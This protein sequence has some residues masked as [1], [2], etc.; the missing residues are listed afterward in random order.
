M[1]RKRA[2]AEQAEQA[3]QEYGERKANDM[4][5]PVEVV[6]APAGVEQAIDRSDAIL[7]TTPEVAAMLRVSQR[8]IAA[9]IE[10]GPAHGGIGS[11]RLDGARRISR[12]QLIDFVR[13]LTERC[14]ATAA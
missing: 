5:R 6:V 13:K 7:L 12:D 3:E 8:K 4:G 2:E 10:R 11:V 9:L 14:A 1:A